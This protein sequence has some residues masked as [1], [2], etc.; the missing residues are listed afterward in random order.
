M[1]NIVRTAVALAAAVPALSLAD[2]ATWNID[3]AHTRVGF[4]V[5]HLVITDVK[6]E[7]AKT[8]G[9][10]TLDDKDLSK[11]SVEASIEASSIDT[12]D[13]KRDGHLKGGDFLEVAK[14]P[15]ITFKST[16]VTPGAGDAIKIEGN[17]TI[18]CVTKPVTLEGEL[19]KEITDPWGNTRRGFSATTKINRRDYGVSFGNA[20]D[21]SPVVGN[22]VKIDIQS[23]LVKAKS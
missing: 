17:L 1:K 11:S 9:K 23:E 22:E 3:S 8:S 2:A 4:S 13:A 10:A 21:V 6:G 19:T 14:C 16:K 15:D 7:F 5:K 12:R 20:A 18:R